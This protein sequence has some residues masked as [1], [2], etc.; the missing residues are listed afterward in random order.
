MHHRSSGSTDDQQPLFR[1]ASLQS[2]LLNCTPTLRPGPYGG[3][4]QLTTGSEG[5]EI[6]PTHLHRSPHLLLPPATH[7][8]LSASEYFPLPGSWPAWHNRCQAAPVQAQKTR[9]KG[10]AT[11]I[12][13]KAAPIGEAGDHRRLSFTKRYSVS[14]TGGFTP[15]CP[16]TTRPDA[17]GDE[18]SV[19]SGESDT[20]APV[21]TRRRGPSVQR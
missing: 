7:R 10:G 11:L 9:G 18:S 1:T 17:G 20:R 3:D 21:Y 8:R 5:E 14:R 6:H 2:G 4:T 19:A 12:R 16:Q 15:G 13:T